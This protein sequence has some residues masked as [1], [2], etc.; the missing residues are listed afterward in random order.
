M[1]AFRSLSSWGGLGDDLTERNSEGEMESE[2]ELLNCCSREMD[3]LKLV[4]A[5]SGFRFPFPSSSLS[6][7]APGKKGVEEG[8]K[9]GLREGGSMRRVQYYRDRMR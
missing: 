4:V 9:A 7:I 2:D 3:C 6:R 5:P 1:S 8:F